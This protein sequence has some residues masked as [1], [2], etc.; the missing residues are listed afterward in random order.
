LV[1]NQRFNSERKQ[2]HPLSAMFATDTH[3]EA[4]E[5]AHFGPKGSKEETTK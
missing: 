4:K 5:K 3:E 2:P 1:V